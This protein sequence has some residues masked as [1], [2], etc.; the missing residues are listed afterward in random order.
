MLKLEKLKKSAE[1]TTNLIAYH[2]DYGF[3]ITGSFGKFRISLTISDWSDNGKYSCKGGIY[4]KEDCLDVELVEVSKTL[5]SEEE[6]ICLLNSMINS[7]IN[8][9]HYIKKKEEYLN[10]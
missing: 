2:F 5:K 8:I 7:S 10:L 3:V 4:L 6:I 1:E 9:E